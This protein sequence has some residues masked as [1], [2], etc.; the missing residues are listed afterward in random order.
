MFLPTHK[1]PVEFS[2]KQINTGQYLVPASPGEKPLAF[3]MS[4]LTSTTRQA[5]YPP[6]SQM[7]N[8]AT[9]ELC[10]QAKVTWLVL[11]GWTW[12][13]QSG[14][15]GRAPH[16]ISS[17]CI[18]K[19]IFSPKGSKCSTHWNAINGFRAILRRLRIFKRAPV[20]QKNQWKKQ[21]IGQWFEEGIEW[22]RQGQSQDKRANTAAW[23]LSTRQAPRTGPWAKRCTHLFPF[24]LHNGLRGPCKLSPLYKR[25]GQNLARL[26]HF[27][28]SGRNEIRI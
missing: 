14:F 23:M 20:F 4:L 21:R 7:R 28:L 13:G 8:Q 6:I 1:V 27:L 5:L 2:A 24:T 11:V 10:A 26:S 15:E 22:H 3:M 18:L 12:P 17:L 16:Y 25:G 19:H 9:E